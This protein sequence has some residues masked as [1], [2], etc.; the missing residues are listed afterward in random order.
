MDKFKKTAL[1][2]A[3]AGAVLAG[4]SVPAQAEGV[5]STA[6]LELKNL[7]FLKDDGSHFSSLDF[8]LLSSTA[9]NEVNNATA[10]LNGALSA[11]PKVT[12]DAFGPNANIDLAPLCVGTGCPVANNDFNTS[13]ISS[14]LGDP[15]VN[16]AYSDSLIAGSVIDRDINGNGVIDAGTYFFD[17]DG[18]AG[19][20]DILVSEVTS[21]SN[22]GAES[23]VELINDGSGAAGVTNSLSS[24]IKFTYTGPTTFFNIAFDAT[25]YME[26]YISTSPKTPMDA[27]AGANYAQTFILTDLAAGDILDWTPGTAAAAGSSTDPFRLTAKITADE[28]SAGFSETRTPTG[29]TLGSVK[30]GSFTAQSSALLVSGRTYTFSANTDTSVSAS[31]KVPE[32]ASIALFGLGLLGLSQIRR[33]KQA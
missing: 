31:L 22:T 2:V 6:T 23:T 16:R 3:L 13:I 8:D 24:T 15:T 17:H 11:A 10:E 4:F 5:L 25:A 21:G 30:T 28:I 32:P 19:T 33:K 14:T 20:P 18:D 12:A 26:T 29:I 9:E 7:L 27:F 1:N